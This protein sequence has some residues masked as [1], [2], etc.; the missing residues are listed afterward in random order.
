MTMTIPTNELI[1]APRPVLRKLRAPQTAEIT[2][3]N[4]ADGRRRIIIKHAEFKGVSPQMLTWWY[5]HY[6]H[7]CT[8]GASPSWSS[9]F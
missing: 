9:N 5:W 8:E 6:L 2:L 4:L 1:P 7:R 3:E